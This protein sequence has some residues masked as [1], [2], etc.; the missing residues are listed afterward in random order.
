MNSRSGKILQFNEQMLNFQDH[1]G[2]KHPLFL[3]NN[4]YNIH[5]QII[6]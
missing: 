6:L 3:K 5:E 1:F 4:K 2:T